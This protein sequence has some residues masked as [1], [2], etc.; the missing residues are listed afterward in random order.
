MGLTR[1]KTQQ[2]L[3]IFIFVLFVWGGANAAPS[4]HRVSLDDLETLKEI[5]TIDLSPDGKLVAFTTWDGDLWFTKTDKGSAP[6][7]LGK[8]IVPRWSPD[9]RKLA[10]YSSSSGTMQLWVHSLDTAQREQITDLEGGINPDPNTWGI[11][12]HGWI[13]DSLRYSWS[14]DSKRLVFASQVVSSG[15]QSQASPHGKPSPAPVTNESPLVL[16]NSTPPEWT[17][18]GI[19]R[20]GGFEPRRWVNGKYNYNLVPQQNPILPPK[21][22]N[23]LLIADLSSK[24]VTQLTTD[25]GIYFAPDWS[26]DGTK[27]VC[28]SFEGRKIAGAGPSNIYA[29]DVLKGE[30]TALTSDAES[31][32]L[33]RW[34]PDGK[35][36]GYLAAEKYHY[37]HVS[38]VSPDGGKPINI[39]SAFDRDVDDFSWKQDSRTLGVL[40][41]DGVSFFIANVR[42][43]SESTIK[44]IEAPEA[45]RSWLR[46]S[47]DGDMAWVE[48]DG[49]KSST[50]QFLSNRSATVYTLV[51]LNPQIKEWDLGAQEVVR[52]KSPDG[53][54]L[55]GILIKPVGYREDQKYPLIVNGYPRLANGFFA[56]P[57]SPG[58]VWA[59]KGY[60]VFY[61][62]PRTPNGWTIPFK[63]EKI[64]QE[65]R[66]PH[67]VDV[68]TEDI[69][70]GVD[71]LIRRGLVDPSRMAL[72]GHSNGGAVVNQVVTKTDRFK[73]AVSVAGALGPDWSRPFFLHTLEPSVPF[74]A[75]V[76]PWEDPQAYL[77]LSAIYRLDRVKTPLLLAVGDDDGDFLLNQIEMYNGLRW[78]GKEVTL[79]RYPGQGHEFSGWAMKDFWRRENSFWETCFGQ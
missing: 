21:T 29:I 48:S 20:S 69:L 68:M 61:P 26:P 10:Y 56:A 57:L 34:S 22:V 9:N 11:G 71:E 40:Y 41:R 66:G 73:C 24:A 45:S 25:E 37:Q 54:E 16:T 33:P 53:A 58:R 2:G 17:L 60:L 79:L 75:G 31:K 42:A 19:F 12:S 49:T 14:P 39:A 59:G 70:S 55:E 28:A 67:G 51:D 46:T 27:I 3:L 30:K 47:R 7:N 72:Y 50:I 77:N 52:W 44:P 65:A 8:G 74:F 5:S 62:D 38:I 13:Y 35:W 78:L 36:I 18:M 6:R 15:L 4:G 63:T 76:T 43:A 1:R 64:D 23:Q 32:R